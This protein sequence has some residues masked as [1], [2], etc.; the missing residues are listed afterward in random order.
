[1]EDYFTSTVSSFANVMVKISFVT[2]QDFIS[3]TLC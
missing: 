3:F 2:V 1:M